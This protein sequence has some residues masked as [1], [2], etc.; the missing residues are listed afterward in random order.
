M[1]R[2]ATTGISDITYQQKKYTFENPAEL[3]D[4]SIMNSK[5]YDAA[6]RISII[7]D[8]SSNKYA[9]K[10]EHIFNNGS[11][12]GSV[13][14]VFDHFD[15]FKGKTLTAEFYVPESKKDNYKVAMILQSTY[16]WI[17]DENESVILDKSGWQKLVF[18]V[19]DSSKNGNPELL[20]AIGFS[21]RKIMI[22]ADNTDEILFT[23]VI[24]K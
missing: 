10:I 24:W 8:S 7:K 2:K 11:S 6:K 15:N 12:T 5:P 1:D 4:W 9:L 3:Y 17:L 13:I 23:N 16:N 20:R 19:N 22:S 21:I 18:N 14:T